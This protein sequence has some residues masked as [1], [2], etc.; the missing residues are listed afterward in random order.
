MNQLINKLGYLISQT[1]LIHNILQNFNVTNRRKKYENDKKYENNKKYK[2][3]DKTTYKN[4]LD[5]ISFAIGKVARNPENLM[6]SDWK[7]VINILKYLNYT[8]KNYKKL[9]TK[10]RE[11]LNRLY[12]TDSD[13]GGDDPKDRKSTS[14]ATSTF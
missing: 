11:E 2:N 10:E 1:Q 9:N 7:K 4:A 14:V 5:H 12:Y 3:F 8:K 6:R 13:F